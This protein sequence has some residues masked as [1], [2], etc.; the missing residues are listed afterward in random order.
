ML[1]VC[2][3]RTRVVRS[4]RVC[5][6]VEDLNALAAQRPV[7]LA[8]MQEDDLVARAVVVHRPHVGTLAK[9]QQALNLRPVEQ[10]TQHER[11]KLLAG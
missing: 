5:E 10:R 11:C 6:P 1:R 2:A 8:C 4:H 3:S 7:G 9:Q